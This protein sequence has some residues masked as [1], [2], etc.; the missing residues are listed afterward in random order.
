MMTD[1]L[2]AGLVATL[3]GLGCLG[4][5]ALVERIAPKETP[6]PRNRKED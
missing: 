6:A 5:I 4:I 1:L 3:A 2:I